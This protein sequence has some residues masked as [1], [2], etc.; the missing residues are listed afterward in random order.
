MGSTRFVSN[1]SLPS[2]MNEKNVHLRK[3]HRKTTDRIYMYI[4]VS[5]R[6]SPADRN[7]LTR[8]RLLSLE[9]GDEEELHPSARHRTKRCI[10]VVVR[11]RLLDD[12]PK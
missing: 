10:I 7:S 9:D 4:F 6:S 3:Y 2:D 1:L 8:F 11:E 12:N 5:N